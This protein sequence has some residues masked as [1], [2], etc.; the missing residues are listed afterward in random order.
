MAN[1]LPDRTLSMSDA[2][3]TQLETQLETQ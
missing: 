2:H 1:Q 3:E